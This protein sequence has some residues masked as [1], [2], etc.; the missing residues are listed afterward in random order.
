LPVKGV[1]EAGIEV[2]RGGPGAAR[3]GEGGCAAV[4]GV[5]RE[6]D[7]VARG[8][9]SCRV[10]T[11]NADDRV[12]VDRHLGAQ[13]WSEHQDT[14]EDERWSEAADHGG[15]IRKACIHVNAKTSERFCG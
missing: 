5:T 6:V 9:D 13:D 10:G 1:G 8:G 7:R 2:E 3:G 15:H 12:E 4:L 11:G 14:G